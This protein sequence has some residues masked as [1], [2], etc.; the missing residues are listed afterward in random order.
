MLCIMCVHSFRDCP[1]EQY[2]IDGHCYE[3]DNG[4][5][6]CTVPTDCPSDQGYCID[7]YCSASCIMNANCGRCIY[8]KCSY[9]QVSLPQILFVQD[10]MTD[11]D[12]G[13]CSE[14]QCAYQ[15][16][17]GG[18]SCNSTVFC[19]PSLT[20]LQGTCQTV[21]FSGT[22]CNGQNGRPSP[23]GTG[24]FCC[25]YGPT[26]P[27]SYFE[28]TPCRSKYDSTGACAQTCGDTLG[29]PGTGLCVT[30]SNPHGGGACA[31]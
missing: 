18:L 8:N 27:T 12:C 21:L 20:C 6:I 28:C 7:G 15:Q 4:G 14:G 23:C 17:Q 5:P 13:I 24:S 1:G 25:S 9:P 19:P 10:C 3:N 2:C 29:I 31:E 11:T 22:A 30:T 16:P 26:S